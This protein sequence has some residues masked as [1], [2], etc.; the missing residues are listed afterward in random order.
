MAMAEVKVKASMDPSGF[1]NGVRGMEGAISRFGARINT[2]ATTAQAA[3]A[4][5]AGLA[6]FRQIKG[7]IDFGG[8]MKDAADNIGLTVEELQVFDKAARRGGLGADKM[9]NALGK[10]AD[11]QAEVIRNPTGNVA[12]AM[13]RLGLSA[14]DVARADLPGLMRQIAAAYAQATD[15]GAALN[16]VADIFGARV[17]VR[18]GS[19]LTELAS[20]FDELSR[21]I[22][23]TTSQAQELDAVGD[24]FEEIGIAAKIHLGGV[25]VKV[26]DGLRFWIRA[27]KAE[28]GELGGGW[29]GAFKLMASN[30]I[31][32]I[33]PL[34]TLARVIKGA[35]TKSIA[36]EMTKE[37]EQRGTPPD[38]EAQRTRER[39]SRVAALKESLARI[40]EE[41]KK[42]GVSL[43]G[44]VSPDSMAAIGGSM[45]GSNQGMLINLA[46]MQLR[47]NERIAELAKQQQDILREISRNTAGGADE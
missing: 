24:A 18:M 12:K 13:E 46:Q 30:A 40:E 5:I 17:A 41:K 31:P 19:T 33:G 4:G 1:Q 10:L 7:I 45:G 39:E 15:K 29:K 22:A 38:I 27:I 28:I 32:V 37:I 26:F 14:D 2:I 16:A 3:F 42:T 23:L 25:L 6:L 21:S 20:N 11:A 34:V 8:E 47:T 9:R 35:R 36:E 43:G 44:L